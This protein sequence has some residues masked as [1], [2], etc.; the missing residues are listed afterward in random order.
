LNELQLKDSIY[1]D[2]YDS[3]YGLPKLKPNK[4]NTVSRKSSSTQLSNNYELEKKK[5]QLDSNSKEINSNFNQRISFL[6]KSINFPPGNFFYPL[7]ENFK[8]KFT[9]Y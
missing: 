9:N 2:G 1:D 8:V 5:S 7:K 6:E 3:D 4:K